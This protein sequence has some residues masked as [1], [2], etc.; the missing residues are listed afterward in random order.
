MTTIG[1]GLRTGQ[2]QLT[3]RGAND[4]VWAIVLLSDGWE[5]TRP[6]VKDVLP[7]IVPTKTRVYT[8][9]LGRGADEALL[10]TIALTTGGFY[11]FAPSGAELAAIYQDIQKA[12]AGLQGIASYTTNILRGV[13]KSFSVGIDPSVLRAVF[14]A[15]IGGSDIDLVLVDPAGNI[16]DPSVAATDPN[17][18]FT[19]G[20][21]YESY[22]VLSPMPG[23][24]QMQVTGVD[25]APGG[26][27]I[28]ASVSGSTDLTLFVDFDKIEYI[29]NEPIVVIAELEDSLGP[30]LGASVVA[31]VQTPSITDTL[32]LYDD[33][34]HQDGAA[35]D[36]VY[37]NSYTNTSERGS[38]TFKVDASGTSNT[39]DAFTRT[40]TKSTVVGRDSDNDGMPDVWEDV[41]GLDKYRDDSAEDPDNDGLTN[42]EEYTYRTHPKNPN[43]DGD[44]YTDGEEVAAGSDPLD[45]NSIPKITGDLDGDLDVDR[46]DLNILLTYRNQPA[47]ACPD[48]DI[49][50]DGRITAL[51]ARKLVLL[52]TRP[53]C[54][55]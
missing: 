14:T 47:S 18:T 53:R 26:E 41:Y 9:G 12:V 46:D 35:D 48:C 55:T 24:W 43:T 52:C 22:S 5:N 23:E 31:N 51:D 49:D 25:V 40:A 27:T 1:G 33:G 39:G 44:G 13:T 38:Y 4:P 32:T 45:P 11:L 8:I 28:T 34:A 2:N 6:M 10:N 54:A 15:T 29:P 50:G 3:S 37:A 7:S 19:S 36:G 30:I 16:I 42:L 21:N 17:I 20:D